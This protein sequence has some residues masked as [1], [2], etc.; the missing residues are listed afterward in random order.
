MTVEGIM[1]QLTALLTRQWVRK[2][3]MT[4]KINEFLKMLKAF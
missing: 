2:L 3:K 1:R 4:N